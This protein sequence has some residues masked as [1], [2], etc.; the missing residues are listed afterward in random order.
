MIRKFALASALAWGCSAAAADGVSFEYGRGEQHSDLW[1]AG[2]QWDWSRKHPLGPHLQWG[3]YWEA[4]G[5]QWTNGVRV[6]DLGFAPVFRLERSEGGFVPYLEAAIGLH[7]LSQV[8]LS[9]HRTSG[10][11]FQFGDHAGLG[12]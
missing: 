7:L 12:V 11:H 3:G 4:S 1:R 5:G 10:T 2:V 8:H 6:T 9:A